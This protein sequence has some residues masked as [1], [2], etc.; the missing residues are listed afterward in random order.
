MKEY[1]VTITLDKASKKSIQHYIDADKEHSA[2]D[3]DF[4]T[5][6]WDKDDGPC[7][8]EGTFTLTA[9]FENGC[10]ADIKVCGSQNSPPWTEGVLFNERGAELCCT[11]PGDDANPAGKWNFEYNGDSYTVTVIDESD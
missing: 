5:G 2:Q 6:F 9:H 3:D 1:S 8:G 11:E 4:W 7:A 10:E